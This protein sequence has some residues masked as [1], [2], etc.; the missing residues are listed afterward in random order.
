MGTPNRKTECILAGTFTQQFDLPIFSPVPSTI[1]PAQALLATGALLAGLAAAAAPG[2]AA[3]AY[4]RQVLVNNLLNP[5]GLT[6]DSFGRVLVSEGGAGGTTCDVAGAPPSPPT[7][8]RCWGTTGAVGR[9]D[10]TT[11]SYTRLWT[12]LDSIARGPGALS[13]VAGLQDLTFSSDGRLLGVFGFRGDPATRPA[14]SSLFAKLVRFDYSDPG[15]AVFP[16]ADLG[17]YESA[18]PSHT[19]PFSNPYALTW[20]GGTSFITDAGANRLLKV[21]DATPST[22]ELLENFPAVASTTPP[23]EAVPT[24]LTVSPG[25]TL[26]NTQLPGYPFQP[27]SASIFSSNGS[28]NSATAITGGF[29]NAM[30]LSLGADGWLYLVQLAENFTNPVGSGSLWRYNPLTSER[31]QLASGIDQPTGVLAMSDGSVYVAAGGST[32][33]GSL[34]YYTPAV[35]GPLPLAGAAMAWN[36]AR[37]LRQRLRRSRG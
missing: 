33:S 9:Y 17:A 5:R 1:R 23:A 22:V 19:P 11:S 24:G 35:P 37:K 6:V 36:M 34:L 21:A 32:T 14:G 16:L 26:Y 18:N 4:N 12:G 13:P 25:G 29:T 31:Q 20:F 7:D 30:D 2:Q 28:A 15:S 3:P 27:G 8:L 10:P